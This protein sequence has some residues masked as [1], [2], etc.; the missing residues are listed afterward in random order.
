M[1]QISIIFVSVSL[2]FLALDIHHYF[3]TVSVTTNAFFLILIIT[4]FINTHLPDSV[5]CNWELICF[6]MPSVDYSI[7]HVFIF[8]NQFVCLFIYWFAHLFICLFK[9]NYFINLLMNSCFY[10]STFCFVILQRIAMK[11]KNT[12]DGFWLQWTL[13]LT[14]VV[15]SDQLFWIL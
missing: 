13:V 6:Y 1:R 3:S 9:Y 7:V 11:T 10:F 14:T 12:T 2:N 15:L 8:I 5:V 4:I